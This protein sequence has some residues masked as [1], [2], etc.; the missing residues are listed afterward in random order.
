MQF[1]LLIARLGP[2]CH[3]ERPGTQEEA[4]VSNRLLTTEFKRILPT[5]WLAVRDRPA[6]AVLSWNGVRAAWRRY[7]SRQGIAQLDSHLLK[8][9]G[10]SFA[11]AEAEAN[12]P[13]WRF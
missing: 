8:D 3:L 12:K 10:V 6:R 7:R 5:D 9:I 11:E 4:A 1:A 13:F 2:P